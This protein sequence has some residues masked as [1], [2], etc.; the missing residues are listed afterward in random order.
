MTTHDCGEYTRR[1]PD[2]GNI[3]KLPSGKSRARYRHKGAL[4]SF[5]FDC[6]C[7]AASWLDEIRDDLLSLRWNPSAAS[8]VDFKTMA[9]KWQRL[10]KKDGEARS[11]NTEYGYESVFR[12]HVFPKLGHI[13]MS[14]FDG[15]IELIREFQHWLTKEHAPGMERTIS[16]A[17]Q[18]T[19]WVLAYAVRRQAIRLN[20]FDDDE[21]YLPKAKK[22]R[23]A[24]DLEQ[25]DVAALVNAINPHYAVPVLLDAYMGLRAGELWA[26]KRS[27]FNP[28]K[29][30]LTVSRSVHPQKGKGLV[31]GP[32]KNGKPRTLVVPDFLLGA[33]NTYL[34]DNPCGADDWLFRTVTGKQVW[35]GTFMKQYYK[36]AV[37]K[38]ELPEATRFHDLRHYCAHFHISQG[39]E[40]ADI[41]ELL[42][43]SSITVTSDI[44]GGLF[45]SRQEEMAAKTDAI[46]RA[47][48]VTR[49]TDV[50]RLKPLKAE[51]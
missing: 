23:D 39:Y 6:E 7:A 8:E 11:Y 41:K 10:Q 42:G 25:D 13:R 37:N 50:S 51:M 46:Y 45:V 20:P 28:I 35:H 24:I 21:V 36:P 19:S 16:K 29:K 33:V 14:R 32:T 17:Q 40:L 38:A 4:T 30:R 5:T 31:I 49:V 2:F 18:Y 12:L 34:V 43:H 1:F 3:G 27:D 44:Y 15:N 47:N 26:L 9:L 48:Q 22:L